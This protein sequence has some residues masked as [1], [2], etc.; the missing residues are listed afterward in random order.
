MKISI[1]CQC[2]ICELHHFHE[3]FRKDDLIIA[4]DGK[5]FFVCFYDHERGYHHITKKG[6]CYATQDLDQISKIVKKCKS[7]Q[8]AKKWLKEISEGF[9]R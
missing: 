9:Y 6:L 5:L 7:M 1:G 4:S 3:V 2:I 8:T